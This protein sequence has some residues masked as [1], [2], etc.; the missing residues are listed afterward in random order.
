MQ[1][2]NGLLTLE[3]VAGEVIESALLELTTLAV[4]PPPDCPAQ[5]INATTTIN[6]STLEMIFINS[7]QKKVKQLIKPKTTSKI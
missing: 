7:S 5:P 4:E 1:T 6:I 2:C 3:R